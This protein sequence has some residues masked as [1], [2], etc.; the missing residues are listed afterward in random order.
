MCASQRMSAPAPAPPAADEQAAVT[1][2][3]G[4]AEQEEEAAD[5]DDDG[6]VEAALPQP[7]PFSGLLIKDCF[8]LD[9]QKEKLRLVLRE[10][11]TVIRQRIGA[12]R[13]GSSIAS[14]DTLTTEV[15]DVVMDL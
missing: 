5:G 1:G 12:R 11:A 10:F 13:D 8:F 3:K 9:G 2:G 7:P 6:G 4:G 15:M 14:D